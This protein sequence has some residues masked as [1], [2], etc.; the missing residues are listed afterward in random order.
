MPLFP[1]QAPGFINQKVLNKFWELLHLLFIGVAVSYGL[2]GRRSNA[3]NVSHDD[4]HSYAYGISHFSSVFE[5]DFDHSVYYSA[6]G[7]VGSFNVK[8]DYK[9]LGLP[10][11]SLKSRVEFGNGSSE[12]SGASAVDSLNSSDKLEG[13]K[14]GDLGFGSLEG[15]YNASDVL[16]SPI[17]WRPRSV[18]M[19]QRVG[20]GA[21]RLSHFRPLSVDETQFQS[22]KSRSFHFELSPHSP[23]SLSPSHSSSSKSLISNELKEFS[24]NKKDDSS[25]GTK[26]WISGY[27]LKF[28]AKPVAPSK[29]SSN[30]SR[31]GP[32][33]IVAIAEHLGSNS[34]IQNP[35][36]SKNQNREQPEYSRSVNSDEETM[37]GTLSVAESD[38]YEVDRKAGEFIANF[39]EQIRLQRTSIDSLKGLNTW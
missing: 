31:F 27:A 10:V 4:S 38:S 15:K 6:Q 20:G 25:S 29:A 17:P 1:S 2:F 8:N 18:R 19:R 11:W 14:S 36:F 28:D 12:F 37:A 26:E 7:K 13:E 39:R 3:D 16:G 32:L 22:I 30:E 34:D 5:D 24:D 35:T 33:E 21:T 23:S 9:P